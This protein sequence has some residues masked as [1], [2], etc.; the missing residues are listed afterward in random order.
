M[1]WHDIR[2][3]QD[4]QLDELAK[5]Y[6]L[7]P[8]HIE[9]CRNRGQSAKL[10]AQSGYLFV[11]VKPMT[12]NNENCLSTGDLDFFIGRDFL[13]TVQE[14]ECTP[15]T[16]ILDRT[17]QMSPVSRPDELFHRI[18]DQVVDAYFPL[19]DG[20]G[21]RM[22]VLED[23]IIENP[24]SKM[25]EEIFDMKRTLIEMRRVLANTRD[26]FGQLL[27]MDTLLIQKDMTPFLRDIH[28]H[29]MRILDNVEIHRDLLTTTTELYLSSVANRTNQVMKALAVFGAVATPALVV[30][31]LYGMNLS[32]LPFAEHPHSWAIV[33]SI[34]GTISTLVLIVLYR[35]RWW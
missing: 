21:E 8:L 5:R 15:L 7:H 17:Q 25:L 6:N 12:L 35:L 22:D 10:E 4:P 26:L 32:K 1:I 24:E 29:V 3:P 19:L 27:R 9:D 18:A 2:D 20:F 16:R 28:D 11:V 14:S 31:G 30:T 23:G 34:I 13:I 33:T